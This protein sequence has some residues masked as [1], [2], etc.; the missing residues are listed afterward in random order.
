MNLTLILSANIFA[1]ACRH[2][3][4][5]EYHLKVVHHYNCLVVFKLRSVTIPLEKKVNKI[6]EAAR[7]NNFPKFDVIVQQMG[8]K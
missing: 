4:L 8:T 5:I 1:L 6:W 7:W 2:P 3:A